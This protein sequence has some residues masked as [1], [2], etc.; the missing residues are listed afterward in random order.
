MKRIRITRL[1]H[2]LIALALSSASLVAADNPFIGRFA[3]NLPGGGAGWLGVEE[4]DGQL[5][6]S[7]LWGGGSVVASGPLAASP[8]QRANIARA[9]RSSRSAASR[10]SLVMAS[11]VSS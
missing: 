11:K 9:L 7:V 2:A 1:R 10:L 8:I 5:S 3:L 4:K 6:S